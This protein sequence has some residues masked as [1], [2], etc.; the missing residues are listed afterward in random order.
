MF[1]HAGMSNRSAR[2][3][4]LVV[5][6]AALVLVAV[7]PIRASA[8]MTDCKD[9]AYSC[10]PGY[11]GGNASGTWAWKYYG[12]QYATTTTGYH[13]CTLYVAWRLSQ[14]GLADPGKSWGNAIDWASNIGGGDHVPA[15]GAVAW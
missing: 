10:T 8:S 7:A 1:R 6:A 3:R 14:N 13:N 9:S 15:V 5:L 11:T 4:I 2:L 12:G